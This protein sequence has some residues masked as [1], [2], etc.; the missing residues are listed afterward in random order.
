MTK[1]TAYKLAIDAYRVIAREAT[2]SFFVNSLINTAISY[3]PGDHLIKISNLDEEGL[4][5]LV[6]SMETAAAK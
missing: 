5:Q 2:N 3:L 6:Q 4:K 1:K